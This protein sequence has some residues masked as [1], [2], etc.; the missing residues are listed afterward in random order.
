VIDTPSGLDEHTL[1]AID[2]STDLVLLCATDVPA[3]RSTLKELEVLR[4]LAQPEQRTHFVL[5]RADARTG[6]HQA[7]IE[8]VVGLEVDVAIPSSGSVPLALNQGTPILEADARSPVS[9]AMAEL[10]ERL[11]PDD[12][13]AGQRGRKRGSAAR[14]RRGV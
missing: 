3:V 9:V 13:F 10:V 7:A 5:N 8:A 14:R 4:V 11:G 1:T 6:L 2:L 12:P